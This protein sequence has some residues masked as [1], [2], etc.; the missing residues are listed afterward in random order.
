MTEA[1]LTAAK[2][3]EEVQAEAALFP[4]PVASSFTINLKN[5][6]NNARVTIM[7]MKGA[8]VFSKTFNGVAQQLRVQ[9]LQLKPGAYTALVQA[10]GVVQTLPFVK[11]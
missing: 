2:Q 6:V 11:Q 8:T 3:A 9:V 4:N 7:D 10:D 5:Q 1:N